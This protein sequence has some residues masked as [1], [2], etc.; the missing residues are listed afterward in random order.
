MNKPIKKKT[1][2]LITATYGVISDNDLFAP[3]NWVYL[4]LPVITSE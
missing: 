4:E 1:S 3:Q 2:V